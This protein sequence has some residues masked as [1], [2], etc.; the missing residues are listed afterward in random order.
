MVTGGGE[1]LESTSC[2]LTSTFLGPVNELTLGARNQ[3][4]QPS[5]F[6]VM[7]TGSDPSFGAF[8]KKTRQRYE[9][10]RLGPYQGLRRGLC[11]RTLHV[12]LS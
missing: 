2:H 7:V 9:L 8:F 1:G 10:L 3:S 6:L 12:K 11:E 4:N 5:P